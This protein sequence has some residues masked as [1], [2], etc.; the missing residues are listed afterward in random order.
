MEMDDKKI[1]QAPSSSTAAMIM[2]TY[3]KLGKAANKLTHYLRNHG[4]SAQAGHPR[5]DGPR[6]ARPAAVPAQQR[7]R[8]PPDGFRKR[9]EWP[10]GHPLPPR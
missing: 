2:Q 5:P 10:G 9:G 7:D 6:A 8:Q 1:E 3:D 4:Y